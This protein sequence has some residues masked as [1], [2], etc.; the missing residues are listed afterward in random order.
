MWKKYC[1][2]YS[3]YMFVRYHH[4]QDLNIVANFWKISV[5]IPLARP[6]EATYIG[7]SAMDK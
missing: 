5:S 1:L 2:K 4:L 6:T 7:K 3:G